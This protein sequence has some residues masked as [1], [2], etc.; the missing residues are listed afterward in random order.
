[1]RLQTWWSNLPVPLRNAMQVAWC[2]LLVFILILFAVQK[3]G[4]IYAAF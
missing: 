1:M 3:H 4:F 2:V